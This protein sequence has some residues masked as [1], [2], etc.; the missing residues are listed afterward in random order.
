MARLD[1]NL[2]NLVTT[3]LGGNNDEV[4][5][6]IV[7]S[8]QGDVY[9]VGET[10]SADFPGIGVQAPPAD[11][12][13]GGNDDGFVAKL[14][15]SLTAILAATFLGGTEGESLSA[16]ALDAAGNPYVGGATLSSDFPGVG[17]Q[18]QTADSTCSPCSQV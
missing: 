7:V 9:V 11:A 2:S 18:G 15:P 16:I 6:A 10:E 3:L 13:I 12:A 17:V 1:L 14:D 8:S 4:M 5:R